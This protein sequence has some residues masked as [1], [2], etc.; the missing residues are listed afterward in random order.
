MN[1]LPL[2]TEKER[3]EY[4]ETSANQWPTNNKKTPINPIARPL[5][6]RPFPTVNHHINI[7]GF[8]TVNIKP[9]LMA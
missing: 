3:K 2:E 7:A 9:F 1:F 4:Q 6:T 5:M 8:K